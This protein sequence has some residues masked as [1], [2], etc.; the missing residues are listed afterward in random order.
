MT[1]EESKKFEDEI[2]TAKD[3]EIMTTV[4]FVEPFSGSRFEESKQW[5]KES[6][7]KY[8]PTQKVWAIHSETNQDDPAYREFK[9]D[10]HEH[11]LIVGEGDLPDNEW[12]ST[13]KNL[14]TLAR[15]VL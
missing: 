4:I 15:R 9:L 11:C 8:L 12:K 7:G 14:G 5:I 2:M 3:D 10:V 13:L 1:E 6:G